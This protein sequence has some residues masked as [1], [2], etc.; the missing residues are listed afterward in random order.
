MPSSLQAQLGVAASGDR[1][2][3]GDFVLWKSTDPEIMLYAP[4]R[5][6]LAQNS[7]RLS[8]TISQFQQW[9]NGSYQM[10]GG[11]ALLTLTSPVPSTQLQ[12]Q[13]RKLLCL[14][15]L[16]PRFLPLP[17]QN[18]R[19]QVLIDTSLGQQS[20]RSTG[21]SLLLELTAA[22]IEQWSKGIKA[23]SAIAGMVKVTYD[24]PRL[25]PAVSAQVTLHG[26]RVFNSLTQLLHQT[27][28]IYGGSASDI[29]AAWTVLLS[30]GDIA[31]QLL[32]AAAEVTLPE[33]IK[34]FSEQ[35]KQQ[36]F[37][38]LFAAKGDRYELRW[39]SRLDAGNLSLMVRCEGWT[40]LEGTQ[41]ISLETLL[42]GLDDRYLNAV[43]R[44][45]SVPVE[46]A[47][48]PTPMLDTVAISLS[49]SDGQAPA[50]ALFDASGG[51]ISQTIQTAHPEQLTVKYHAKVNFA[52]LSWPVVELE[53]TLPFEQ[54]G[55]R[56]VLKP[57]QWIHRHEIYFMV[58]RGDRILQPHEV[59]PEDYLVLNAS[60]ESEGMRSIKESIRLTP[61]QM[62]KFC[63]PQV[64][65]APL[66]QVKL[67]AMGLI[68]GQMVKSA[69]LSLP[70]SDKPVILF[71]SQDR[72]QLVSA[73]SPLLEDDRLAQRL[74]EAQARPVMTV[75][76]ESDAIAES[77]SIW[78]DYAVELVPQPTTVSCWAAALTMVLG[79]RDRVSYNP[80]YVASVAGL[81]LTTGYGWNK[82]RKAVRAWGLYERGPA[83]AMPAVWASWLEWLGPM[84]IVE[85]GAPYHAVVLT[86]MQGDGTPE[87][88]QVTI[89][90]P[91]PPQQGA[92][93]YKSFLEFEQEFGLGAGAGAAIVHG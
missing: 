3:V 25:M 93:E 22:G 89:Y 80:E 21:E 47:V 33:M 36:I 87:G 2:D 6:M 45:V 50:V 88:T 31:I 19:A 69:V 86:G 56:L 1:T 51:V 53:G 70:N 84:W 37:Q 74:V 65:N 91:W 18:Y 14:E 34:T 71:A 77:G 39:R 16:T 44:E 46:L 55:Y 35:A 7:D 41:E 61:M 9:Q 62:M 82:I 38:I 32:N 30:Q 85:V 23:K 4:K 60:Y 78:V 43:Y 15:T 28:G 58:R 68:G 90:N 66:G 13:W 79:Y 40:W 63:Y 92:I 42:K 29:Q 11:S 83:S 24:Y 59:D 8:A 54:T 81:N 26:L 76:P 52:P 67:S 48:D 72:I 12:T 10:T 75:L 20:D 27:N 49:V 17:M 64:P 57:A 73:D 5:P